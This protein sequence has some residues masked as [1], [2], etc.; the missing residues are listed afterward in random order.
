MAY[1]LETA[2]GTDRL[3]HSSGVFSFVTNPSIVK[4]RCKY[5]QIQKYLLR[6]R[7]IYNQNKQRLFNSTYNLEEYHDSVKL[8]L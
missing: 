2:E 8:L 3:K 1:L 7:D 5:D 6:Q 4:C